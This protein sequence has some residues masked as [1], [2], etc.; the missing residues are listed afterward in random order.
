MDNNFIL[1]QN[2]DG[3]ILRHI[4]QQVFILDNSDLQ[5]KQMAD[6]IKSHC[7]EL[8]TEAIF[9]NFE[10][11]DK[12]LHFYDFDCDDYFMLYL[13]IGFCPQYDA[14]REFVKIMH[15]EAMMFCINEE[16]GTLEISKFGEYREVIEKMTNLGPDSI[17]NI[18]AKTVMETNVIA[19][20]FCQ[21]YEKF[22]LSKSKLYDD[23]VIYK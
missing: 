9:I 23:K 15:T 13:K 8:R 3:K 19:G 1:I 2:R 10:P 21:H 11:S 16:V 7:K 6:E 17:R 20:S 12:N 5:P 4:H 18:F 22:I 14:L